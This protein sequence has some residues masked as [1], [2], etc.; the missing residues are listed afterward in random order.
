MRLVI[1]VLLVALCLALAAPAF[2]RA[3]TGGDYPNVANLTA[4][5]PEANFMSLPGYLRLLVWRDQ[6]VWLTYAEAAKIVAS[7]QAG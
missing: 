4:Y 6:G 3:G 5:S 2:A 1:V 7:Q